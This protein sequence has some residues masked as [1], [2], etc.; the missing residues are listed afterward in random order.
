MK[1]V[2]NSIAGFSKGKFKGKASKKMSL[3]DTVQ[4][5]NKGTIGNFF[6]RHTKIKNQKWKYA[7]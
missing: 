3:L 7:L 4:M 2:L 6:L 5:A 1:E